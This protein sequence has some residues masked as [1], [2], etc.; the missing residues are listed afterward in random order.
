MVAHCGAPEYADFVSLVDRHPN[1]HLDT[2][3]VFTDFTARYAPFPATLLPRL[4]DLGHR[5]VFGSDY[6]NIPYPYAHQVD[7]LARLDFGNGWLRAV[8]HDNGVRL[9]GIDRAATT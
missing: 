8:L 7:V 6:P 9:T 2:T 5:T 1:V 4:R 3:M